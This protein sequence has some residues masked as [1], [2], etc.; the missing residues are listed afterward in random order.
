MPD[1]IHVMVFTD[2][3][4]DNDTILKLARQPQKEF[5]ET[6]IASYDSLGK[7]ATRLA[8][9]TYERDQDSPDVA[10]LIRLAFRMTTLTAL[11]KHAFID[12]P[13]VSMD[14]PADSMA[15][16]N[17]AFA[18]LTKPK[19]ADKAHSTITKKRVMRAARHHMMGGK[20][21]GFCLHCGNSATVEPHAQRVECEDCGAEEVYGNAEILL[22]GMFHADKQS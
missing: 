16:I 6:L 3:N 14:I 13:A 7:S 20:P 21:I 4:D 9:L 22:Q 11:L 1:K 18:N 15:D 12:D 5:V 2:D 17:A 19:N 8:R 10:H